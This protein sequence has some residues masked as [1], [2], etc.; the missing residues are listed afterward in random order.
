MFVFRLLSRTCFFVL[1]TNP[2]A[3]A[4]LRK[5]CLRF[6]Q[7]YHPLFVRRP[8]N[9][10][11]LLSSRRVPNTECIRVANNG[12]LGGGVLRRSSL[13]FCSLVFCLHRSFHQVRL[14]RATFRRFSSIPDRSVSPLPSNPSRLLLFFFS[15]CSRLDFHLRPSRC[16]LLLRFSRIASFLRT[17]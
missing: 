7:N 8:L 12:C 3:N 5:H 17:R 10:L 11:S 16:F 14:S 4:L 2:G 1:L 13:F 6:T 9:F 15:V